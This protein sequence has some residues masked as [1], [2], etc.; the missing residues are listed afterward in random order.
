M[1]VMQF[2]KITTPRLTAGE[3]INTFRVGTKWGY[4]KPG[5][6]IALQETLTGVGIG[7][8][9]VHSVRVGTW[10]EV[11]GH[12]YDN[13]SWRGTDT[14]VESLRAEIEEVYGPINDDTTLIT[15]VYFTP[16]IRN[17]DT[18]VLADLVAERAYQ[19]EKWGDADDTKNTP[20]DFVGYISRYATRWFTG[21]FRPYDRTELFGFRSSMV[22]V[23]TLAFAAI[24][25]ADRLLA[26][27]TK[28]ADVLRD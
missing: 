13:Q 6:I 28:R 20:M 18:A 12:A 9:L 15:V 16:S 26:G 21:G 8:G 4:L 23:G 27:R 19:I 3:L 10:N 17:D 22:K 5:E 2:G 7:L 11:K 1:R 24:Q 25:Y 14:P